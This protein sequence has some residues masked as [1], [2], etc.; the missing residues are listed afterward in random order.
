[1]REAHE[2]VNEACEFEK[3]GVNRGKILLFFEIFVL[4]SLA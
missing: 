2:R 4:K 3:R 1:M